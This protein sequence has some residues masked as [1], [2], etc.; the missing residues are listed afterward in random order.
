V[1]SRDIKNIKAVWDPVLHKKMGRH[2]DLIKEGVKGLSRS[3]SEIRSV[4]TKFERDETAEL[5]IQQFLDKVPGVREV[6][7]Q[8]DPLVSQHRSPAAPEVVMTYE[9]D[10][11]LYD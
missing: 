1:E 11:H 6:V 5:I 7:S 4:M 9:D 8:I 2:L 10:D 3:L